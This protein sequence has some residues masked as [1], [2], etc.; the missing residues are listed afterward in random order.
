MRIAWDQAFPRTAA[1]Y[2]LRDSLKGHDEYSNYTDLGS[3][4][5]NP[6]AIIKKIQTKP[7][8][9]SPPP[10]PT[11]IFSEDNFHFS[12]LQIVRG[13]LKLILTRRVEIG[14]IM[15]DRADGKTCFVENA[16]RTNCL[17]WTLYFINKSFRS[18]SQVSTLLQNSW[19]QIFITCVVWL[20][21]WIWT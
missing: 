5:C 3:L 10:P 21:R 9:I 7:K 1:M 8:K 2:R 19:F 4:C 6:Q 14:Y 12:D 11:K 20:T 13:I 15:L 18:Q 16:H 17:L